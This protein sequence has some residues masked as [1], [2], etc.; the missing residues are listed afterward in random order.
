[1]KFSAPQAL[2]TLIDRIP[3]VVVVVSAVRREAFC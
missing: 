3:V 2:V 1:M